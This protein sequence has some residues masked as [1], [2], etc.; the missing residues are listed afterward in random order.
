MSDPASASPIDD[1]DRPPDIPDFDLIRRIGEGG[2]G[3][4][5]LA[6]NRATGH[7]RAVKVIALKNAASTD[8]AGREIAS[9]TE[10][11]AHVRSQHLN[12]LAIHHVAQTVDYVFYVMDPA[13]DTSGNPASADADYRPATL[14]SL[15][16]AGPL[17]PDLCWRYAEQLLAGLACL[18][19]AGMV[20]R[21]VKPSN[22][23]FVGGEL[24]L[25]DFGL[26]TKTDREISRIGTWKYMPPDGQMDARADVYAAGLVI[27]QMVT[28]WSAGRFPRLSKYAPQVAHD[29]I[30]RVLNRLSL[31]AC[32]REPERRFP[33]ARSML[34]QMQ[35]SNPEL[36]AQR[37]RVWRRVVASIGGSALLLS[38]GAFAWRATRPPLVPVNFITYPFEATIYLDKEPLKD[39]DGMFYRTPC[40]VPDIP[41]R[42]HHVVFRHD[43]QGE[44]DAGTIDF[45]EKRHIRA[46]WNSDS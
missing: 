38:V 14:E 15:L 31:H 25:G 42:V 29:P 20:H 19:D 30:R 21:D 3:E 6:T 9:L 44:L 22:C 5:W 46:T 16:A 36:T 7:L 32:Q 28:G 33:D 2:F 41:A 39:P 13:D 1:A 4:V 37:K 18:H 26:V 40:T 45:A 24:K 27:Y 8:P 17:P 12:L 43:D 34:A 35:A 11:E 10:L 23:L